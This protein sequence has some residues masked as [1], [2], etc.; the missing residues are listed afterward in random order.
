M[1]YRAFN[2]QMDNHFSCTQHRAAHLPNLAPALQVIDYWTELAAI[3][4][5]AWFNSSMI[6]AAGAVKKE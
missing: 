1:R 6:F 5:Y 2:A 4:S 3:T